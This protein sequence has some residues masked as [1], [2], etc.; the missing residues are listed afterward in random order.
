[1]MG[2]HFCTEAKFSKGEVDSN[3]VGYFSALP[4]FNGAMLTWVLQILVED[5]LS[6][7]F[8]FCLQG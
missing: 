5:K 6:L 2:K 4:L 3:K 1:M 7:D 8:T